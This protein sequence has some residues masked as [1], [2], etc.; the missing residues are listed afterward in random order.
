MGFLGGV[1]GIAASCSDLGALLAFLQRRRG[2]EA[3]EAKALSVEVLRAILEERTPLPAVAAAF[4]T[5]A[6]T[7]SSA[8]KALQAKGMTSYGRATPESTPGTTT[9]ASPSTS[10]PPGLSGWLPPG[11]GTPAGGVSAGPLSFPPPVSTPGA[12]GAAVQSSSQSSASA[13][14]ARPGGSR[15]GDGASKAVVGVM[16][17]ALSPDEVAEQVGGWGGREA[18]DV[19]GCFLSGWEAGGGWSQVVGEVEA[20]VGADG[21]YLVGVII[22]LIRRSGSPGARQEP[23]R[24]LCL[25]T[26]PDA[27][28]PPPPPSA[29]WRR[30]V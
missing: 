23:S 14:S 4:D 26:S 7:Y 8:V 18:G 22:E 11:M 1:Q 9:T 2:G 10:P 20:E 19:V 16:G 24:K 17:A 13:T 21:G 28:L 30:A 5:V 27:S 6:L 3:E 29:F 25:T 15:G 12:Q